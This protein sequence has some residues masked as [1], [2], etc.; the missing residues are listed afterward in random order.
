MSFIVSE[1]IKSRVKWKVQPLEIEGVHFEIMMLDDYEIKAIKSCSSYDNMLS[2]AAYFGL[3]IDSKSMIHNQ[4][5]AIHIDHLWEQEILNQ[6]CDPC[7]KYRL[8]EIVCEI[9]GLGDVLL[10]RLEADKQAAIAIDGDNLGDTDVTL[11]KLAED[12]A[13]A[14][15][16]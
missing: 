7:I 11:E 12:A 14:A 3:S 10:E 2:L 8:G 5:Y 1:F 9:S 6:D 13:V 4:D 16:A 15:A